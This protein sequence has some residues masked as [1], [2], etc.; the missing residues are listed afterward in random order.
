M[1]EK[2]SKDEKPK[3]VS[4]PKA[5]IPYLKIFIITLVVSFVIG[6]VSGAFFGG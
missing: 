6:S 1:L 4:E 5:K 3:S 2:N